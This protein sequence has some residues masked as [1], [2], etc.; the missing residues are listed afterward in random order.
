MRKSNI[1]SGNDD[2]GI[3][4][5][6][7]GSFD[8]S[9][10]LVTGN[11]AD[12]N[13]HVGIEVQCRSTVTFNNA[14]NNDGL[15]PVRDTSLRRAQQHVDRSAGLDWD[16]A[17]S[18]GYVRFASIAMALFQLAP[19]SMEISARHR[20]ELRVMSL[21]IQRRCMPFEPVPS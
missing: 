21:K 19:A 12:D 17:G 14:A 13:G 4:V 18:A 9:R 16:I 15:Q 5:G 11:T 10:S 6:A 8:G 7:D 1:A 2:D 3:D 20:N